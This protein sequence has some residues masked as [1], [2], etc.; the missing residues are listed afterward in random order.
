MLAN[1]KEQKLKTFPTLYLGKDYFSFI[2]PTTYSI[3]LSFTLLF[4]FPIFAQ[5]YDLSPHKKTV[6]DFNLTFLPSSLMGET[7]FQAKAS[8]DLQNF[9]ANWEAVINVEIDTIVAND[10]SADPNAVRQA[11]ELQKETMRS[12]M[13]QEVE[14]FIAEEL[15]N[16]KKTL[17]GDSLPVPELVPPTFQTQDL[18]S[19][20]TQA[21]EMKNQNEWETM[22]SGGLDTLQRNW[23]ANINAQID[24]HLANFDHTDA[25]TSKAEYESYLRNVLE[26]QKKT[27]AK[28]WQKQADAAVQS[29]R[30]TF[31][32]FLAEKNLKETTNDTTED[33]KTGLNETS[34]TEQDAIKQITNG[35]PSQIWQK[36]EQ[37]IKN[38][39]SS[40]WNDFRGQVK[41]GQYQY[42]TAIANLDTEYSQLVGAL[43]KTE[44]QFLANIDEINSYETR[45]LVGIR[46]TTDLLQAS[47]ESNGMF[48]VETCDGQ[49]NCSVDRDTLN[50]AGT[51]L[52]NLISDIRKGLDENAPIS[53]LTKTITDYLEAQKIRAERERDKWQIEIRKTVSSGDYIHGT[54]VPASGSYDRSTWAN[55]DNRILHISAHPATSSVANYLQ[56]NDETA[57]RSYLE[58]NKG[59]WRVIEAIN[60]GGTD[61]R[62]THRNYY[63]GGSWEGE[64]NVGEW[65][66]QAGNGAFEFDAYVHHRWK[67]S[68]GRCK[69]IMGMSRFSEPDAEVRIS[70]NI[71]NPNAEIN[72]ANWSGYTDD[73]IAMFSKWKDELLPAVNQWESAAAKYRIEYSEWKQEADQIRTDAKTAYDTNRTQLIESR[74]QWRASMKKQ[75]RRGKRKWLVIRKRLA[76]KKKRFLHRNGEG[77][78][79]NFQKASKRALRR[80]FS[81][82][83][84]QKMVDVK[85]EIAKASV[86]LPKVTEEFLARADKSVPN[87]AAAKTI[88][89][90]FQQTARGMLNLTVARS[91]QESAERLRDRQMEEIRKLLQANQYEMHVDGENLVASRSVISGNVYRARGEGLRASDYDDVMITQSFN[92][93]L[94]GTA[95]MVRTGG[96]LENWDM[97]SLMSE[98]NGNMREAASNNQLAVAVNEELK[99]NHEA[100]L[101]NHEL[102][103][104]NI[105]KGIQSAIYY[106]RKRKKGLGGVLG[107]IVGAMLGGLDLGQ[108]ITQT[109]QNLV[110]NAIAESTGLPVGFI[111]GMVGGE[112]MQDAWNNYSED[113]LWSEVDRISGFN[114]LSSFVRNQQ[115]QDAQNDPR[116][117]ASASYNHEDGFQASVDA[118]FGF[119]HISG[120]VLASEGNYQTSSSAGLEAGGN[121]FIT[122]SEMSYNAP[123]GFQTA[124]GIG[125]E[126]ELAGNEFAAS[127]TTSYSNTDGFA[128]SSQVHLDMQLGSIAHVDMASETSYSEQ[129]G[130]DGYVA[131]GAGVDV[132]IA[133]ADMSAAA[134]YSDGNF[135]ALADAGFDVGNGLLSADA[136]AAAMYSNGNLTTAAG[137][138]ASAGWGLANVG[139]DAAVTASENGFVGNVGAGIS[140]G[141]GLLD[142]DM[143]AVGGM[144]NGEAIGVLTGDTQVGWG[145]FESNMTLGV[146]F[147]G[148]NLSMLG[149][150]DQDLAGINYGGAE[151]VSVGEDGLDLVSGIDVDAGDAVQ[152][153]SATALNMDRDGNFAGAFDGDIDFGNGA[154]TMDG[155]GVASYQDGDFE[156]AGE[157]SRSYGYGFYTED[158]RGGA[159]YSNGNFSG[160]GEYSTS[161]FWGMNQTNYRGAAAYQDGNFTG[162]GD[163]HQSTFYGMNETHG[164]GMV[165]YQEGNFSGVGEYSQS[166]FYGM[167]ESNSSGAFTAN[168]DSLHAYG[169]QSTSSLWGF[170]ETSSQ[171]MANYEDNNFSAL[172]D[173][174]Q[175]NMGGLTGMRSS[176]GF[177]LQEGDA[178]FGQRHEAN[179]PSGTTVQGELPMIYTQEDGFRAVPGGH[180]ELFNNLLSL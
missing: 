30:E 84:R 175:S 174:Q 113:T 146:T 163:Y 116:L 139:L 79:K 42:Q 83:P 95:E 96:L 85:K 58:N 20:F 71:Y 73:I 142:I 123:D 168:R 66:S 1:R 90:E 124:G 173:T 48:Y 4:A 56:T 127:G 105:K 143:D 36:A 180:E 134:G 102:R 26:A 18:D 108:A 121:R 47:L 54:A 114:G 34:S 8:A 140:A 27:A 133:S 70:Y 38:A 151:T 178:L 93:I 150:I 161:N 88:L 82:M 74:D 60:R 67:C 33:T 137:A 53:E 49:H 103:I 154:Y 107:S 144:Q 28:D 136:T 162:V 106:K 17:Q 29:R 10:T 80:L 115:E 165:T 25:F 159:E 128:A 158:Y 100:L 147:L 16:Y 45:V 91:L 156:A 63:S 46:Q 169:Q 51:E 129:G 32:A 44:N 41:D 77:G 21:D 61:M 125:M 176:Y 75:Y 69:N 40:W 172:Y 160:A 135:S 131:G 3:L 152:G 94:P 89:A 166:S 23:E 57:I 177:L 87:S 6:Q 76:K 86:A 126:F 11:L 171:G 55:P 65:Y 81:K 117:E 167:N 153:N 59:E 138:D 78:K 122:E 50:Q 92:R 52:S 43:D 119:G 68:W 170:N 130:F 118:G 97:T 157:F 120:D 112:N 149:G 62:G 179:G 132:G 164:Q 141:H 98:F 110:S 7:D 99:R 13:V 72:H 31:V 14:N 64:S 104:E 22:V 37:Y 15:N 24:S 109:T 145:L 35:D 39:Q 5:N 12:E 2:K 101:R 9:E 155:R 111:S 148:N 19:T